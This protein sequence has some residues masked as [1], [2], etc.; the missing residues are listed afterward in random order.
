MKKSIRDIDVAGKRALVRV[1]F[2]VPLK[3]GVVQDDTRVRAALPTIRYLMDQGARVMILSHLGRP[4]GEGFE[5]GFSLLPVVD[6][7]SELLGI[8]VQYA[9]GLTGTDV[10]EAV[11][12]LEDGDVLLL[13]NVRF[14]KRE[15]ANDPEFA[16]ELAGLAD[17]FVNDAFGASHRAHASTCGVADHLPSVCGELMAREVATITE[18]MTEP[19][20][21]FVAILGGSKV[22]DKIG[23]MESLID[24]CDALLVGGGMCFTF[25]KAL[26][27]EVGTSICEESWV[28]RARDLLAKAEDADVEFMLPEDIVAASA[29]SEDADIVTCEVDSIP[30]GMMGLDIGPRSAEAYAKVI[31]GAETI[32]WNGPMGV[33]EMKPFA[34]GTEV[35]AHAVADNDHATSII[36]G[37]DSVAAIKRYGLADRVSFISTGGGASMRLVEGKELPGLEALDDLED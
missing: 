13:E 37:G 18:M 14:D 27:H 7:L 6:T 19:E 22:S 1:D 23:V 24:K 20:R 35:V 28:D 15:Q 34:N 25:L 5:E 11:L 4:S 16:C 10:E 2:N 29:F 12:A 17:I 21:P 32:F 36:G 31:A 33:F 3:D 26:G 30:R 8:E 9:A